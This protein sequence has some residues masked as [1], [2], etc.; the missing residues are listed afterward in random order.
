MNE[1]KPDQ[2]PSRPQPNASESQINGRNPTSALISVALRMNFAS[3]APSRTPSSA[4]TIPATGNWATMNHHGTPIASSTDRSSVKMLGNTEAP[5]AKMPANTAD[6]SVEKIVTRHA[7]V[8]VAQLSGA[9]RRAHQRLRGERRFVA[10]D[11]AAHQFGVGV[12]RINGVPIRNRGHYA[13]YQ[14]TRQ[15][16]EQ[17]AEPNARLSDLLVAARSG[18]G[19]VAADSRR[20]LS[21]VLD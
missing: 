15:S 6:A 12:A 9:K 16:L 3:P 17:L 18:A 10:G 7:T 21:E 13:S 14:V 4:K 8:G 19:S 20:I 2:M 5:T 11:A 1:L